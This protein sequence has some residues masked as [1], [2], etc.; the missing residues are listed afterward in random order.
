MVREAGRRF[1]EE[2]GAGRVVAQDPAAGRRTKE[3][4]AIAVVVSGG[5]APR[6]VPDLSGVV[7]AV[8]VDR[9]RARRLVPR[10]VRRFDEAA[11]SG[12]VLA[13]EHAGEALPR[14]AEVVVTVSD[15]PAP[16]TVPAL[17]GRT[18]DEAAAE[19]R[20]IGLEPV[21]AEAFSDAVAAGEVVATAPG[22][23]ASVPRGERVTLTVSKGPDL[24][25]VPAVAGRTVLDAT[26]AVRA[27]GLRVANV[28]GSPDRPVTGSSPAAGAR[29]KRGS[30]VDLSTG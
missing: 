13:W 8:A 6:E 27:A 18:Y 4:D 17:A 26:A 1:D 16:R 5:P 29:A 10:V 25:T 12:A 11:P 2:L 9:L 30:G 19:L 28:A 14:D 22:A 24:V 7:E 21:R 3:G 15:G 23:D 20:R